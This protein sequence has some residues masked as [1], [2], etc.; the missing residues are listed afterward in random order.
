M[1]NKILNNIKKELEQSDSFFDNEINIVID[2]IS[3]NLD[4]YLDKTNNVSQLEKIKKLI[5]KKVGNKEC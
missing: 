4:K 2:V 1:K 5:L 3:N